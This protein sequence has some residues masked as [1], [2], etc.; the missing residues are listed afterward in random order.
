MQHVPKHELP[1]E[2][3][4]RELARQ[5]LP[6]H[7]LVRRIE[8]RWDDGIPGSIQADWEVL[9]EYENQLDEARQGTMEDISS[10]QRWAHPL[11]D[12][13]RA[14]WPPYA[15]RIKFAQVETGQT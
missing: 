5:N 15:L 10:F 1:D 2:E 11:R 9:I 6:R 13:I 7:I 12:A 3:E 8:C 4:I 14:K